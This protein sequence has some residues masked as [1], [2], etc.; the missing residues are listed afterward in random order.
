VSREKIE[1]LHRRTFTVEFKVEA[2]KLKREQA[3]TY[4]EV[5]RRLNVSP[6]LIR[7]WE[8]QYDAGELTPEQ[9]KRRISPESQEISELRAQ[10]SRLKMENAI[11]KKAAAYFAKESV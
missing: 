3:L 11:L 2:V 6:R 9:A 1:K 7:H 8:K 5:G 10:V 4:A